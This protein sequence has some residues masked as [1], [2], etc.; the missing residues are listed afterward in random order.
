MHS[1]E[2]VL[3]ILNFSHFLGYQ[4]AVLYTLMMLG[5]SIEPQLPVSHKGKQPV[6]LKPFC[7]SLSV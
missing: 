1:V 7:F 2:A 5:S 3:Q 6:H 4:Y